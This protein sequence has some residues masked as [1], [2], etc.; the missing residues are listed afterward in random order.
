MVV[1][2]TAWLKSLHQDTKRLY[3]RDKSHNTVVYMLKVLNYPL[4]EET[5]ERFSWGAR[6]RQT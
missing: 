2:K 3:K 4:L 5:Q 6:E 1:P